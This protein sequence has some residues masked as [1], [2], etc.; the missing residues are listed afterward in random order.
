MM[1]F[2]FTVR[3]RPL[4][5]L[6]LFITPRIKPTL[7]KIPAKHFRRRNP[8]AP[9]R[10]GSKG[11]LLRRLSNRQITPRTNPRE[12]SGADEYAVARSRQLDGAFRHWE[13]LYGY[14]EREKR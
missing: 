2:S 1:L 5:L 10:L 3:T 7:L 11:P 6:P 4:I 12:I 14:P 9:E 13:D 8:I